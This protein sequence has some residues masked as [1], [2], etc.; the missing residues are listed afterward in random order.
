MGTM[1]RPIVESR[2][3]QLSSRNEHYLWT[4]KHLVNRPVTVFAEVGEEDGRK[5][6]KYCQLDPDDIE[7]YGRVEVDIAPVLPVDEQGAQLTGWKLFQEGG[8]T[9]EDWVRDKLKKSNPASYRKQVDKDMARRAFMP[10]AIK[11]AMALGRVKLTNDIAQAHGIDKLNS[12]G[13]LDI[14][15]LKAA[16]AT[17][18]PP[19]GPNAPPQP[20]APQPAPGTPTGGPP[21]EMGPGPTGPGI[22]PTVGA[23]PNDPTPAYRGT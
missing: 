23:N 15:A 10:E 5:V 17:Q 18:Q 8:L 21:G 1:W 3:I 19:T 4:V 7:D 16:R 14:Q 9:W 2:Q 6:G 12:I 22:A 20:P 13:Q 11:D